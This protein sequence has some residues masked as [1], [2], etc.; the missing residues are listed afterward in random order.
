ML[1]TYKEK[2]KKK[3]QVYLLCKV[4]PGASFNKL[5]NLVKNNIEGRDVEILS[6]AISAPPE[7]NKANKALIKLLS[8]EFGVISENVNIISGSGERLKL[9][10]LI[11]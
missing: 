9:I 10:K 11:N 4:F 7:K 8:K 3:G 1:S 2:L 5:K 6:I